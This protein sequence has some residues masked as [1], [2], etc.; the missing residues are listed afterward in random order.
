MF[1]QC[2]STVYDENRK[3]NQWRKNLMSIK[4]ISLYTIFLV[5]F[6]PG[7]HSGDVITCVEKPYLCSEVGFSI[8]YWLNYEGRGNRINMILSSG[9]EDNV[10]IL[11]S[12]A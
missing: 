1:V 11:P 10:C 9:A 2:W 6:V 7:E 12:E 3:L 5:F 8:V 4:Y